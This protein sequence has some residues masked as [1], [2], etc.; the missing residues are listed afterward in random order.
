MQSGELKPDLVLL[1]D[2]AGQFFPRGLESMPCPTAVYLIDVHLNIELREMLVPF[3]DYAFV[4]QRDYVDHFRALRNGQV[5]WLPLA[6]DPEIHGP[7]SR[8][9]LWD[10]G[11]V[12]HVHS[13]VR[14]RRLRLLAER[15]RVN[16]YEHAYPRE[17]IAEIYSQSKIVFN[18]SI[19]GDLNMRV[20]EAMASGSMLITDHIPNGQSDLFQKGVHLV[21]YSNDDEL[22]AQV[23][24]YLARDEERERIA[25]AAQQ[26]VLARH[27]YAHRCQLILDTVFGGRS[28]SLAATA[29]QMDQAGIRLAYALIYKNYMMVE[30]ILEELRIAWKSRT[31]RARVLALAFQVLTKKLYQ[32]LRF[33]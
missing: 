10:V 11:F 7:R 13:Q 6:C 18:S 23:E 32:T 25:K 28:P 33:P 24:Y 20:F 16:E 14:A 4:A 21:E 1:I 3:F 19:N 2:P 26:E 15:F 29:R 31:E 22:V 27:T 5:E 12:G 17:Q 9:K 8:T 30:A